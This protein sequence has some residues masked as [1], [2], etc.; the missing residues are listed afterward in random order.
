MWHFFKIRRISCIFKIALVSDLKFKLLCG[1]KIKCCRYC[2]IQ[3]PTS[4]EYLKL[5]FSFILFVLFTSNPQMQKIFIGSLSF[6]LFPFFFFVFWVPYTLFIHWNAVI[7]LINCN[8][9]HF[10]FCCTMFLILKETQL[11]QQECNYIF[12][13]FIWRD[14][15]MRI[16]IKIWHL[17]G[18][19]STYSIMQGN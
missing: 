11:E 8:N 9:M 15:L 19:N 2:L 16:F 14:L 17:Y 13:I 10:F 12:P 18:Q 4:E 3:I 5:L 6:L 7:V 1:K